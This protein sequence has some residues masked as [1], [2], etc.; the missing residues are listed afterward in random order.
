MR[1]AGTNMSDTRS[2]PSMPDAGQI[3]LA[4]KIFLRHAYSEGQVP[5]RI[6][7]LLP[8]GD[9]DPARYLMSDRVERTPPDAPLERVRSFA[10]RLGNALYPH[11][12]L[13][14]SRP[15]N[16]D[17]LV[18]SVDSHDAFL[19]APPDSPDYE[20]LERLKRRNSA[21]ASAVAAEWDQAHLPTEKDYLRMKI[22]QARG[23]E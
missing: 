23:E 18:L 19:S 11:M 1:L 21:I 12:K 5:P 9:F 2:T 10:L 8:E 16:A 6:A 3:R 13:R 15:P 4:I 22:R 14:L 20:E 17:T 7:A